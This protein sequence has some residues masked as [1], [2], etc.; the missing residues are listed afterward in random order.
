MI[1]RNV[2]LPISFIADIDGGKKRSRLL[3]PNFEKLAGRLLWGY[4]RA[5]FRYY[6]LFNHTA[7]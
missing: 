5:K 2:L 7:F 1:R 6:K 4:V 3:L